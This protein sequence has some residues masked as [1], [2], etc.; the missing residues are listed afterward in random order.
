[1][2][3]RGFEVAFVG[4]HLGKHF[5][6]YFGIGRFILELGMKD[7]FEL[8]TRDGG[9]GLVLFVAH[10]VFGCYAILVWGECLGCRFMTR[11]API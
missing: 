1:M 10:F 8:E 2:L 11:D 4:S 9:C 5:G 7:G 6:T 3:E